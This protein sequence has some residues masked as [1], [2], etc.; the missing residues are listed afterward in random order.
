MA[1]S[2]QKYVFP[3]LDNT[4]GKKISGVS[5]I[6]SDFV[7]C[8]TAYLQKEGVH[9]VQGV[10]LPGMQ[11]AK[12]LISKARKDAGN[13]DLT[14]RGGVDTSG[15][16]IV[17]VT[18]ILPPKKPG[19]SPEKYEHFEI[20]R[21]A[22]KKLVD[23][24]KAQ[25]NVVVNLTRIS[26]SEA[27]AQ[28]D[29]LYQKYKSKSAVMGSAEFKALLKKYSGDDIINR[30]ADKQAAKYSTIVQKAD[31]ADF[32][33]VTT[34][35]VVLAAHGGAVAVSGT[36]IGTSLG[37]KSAADIVKLLTQNS[38]KKKNLSKTFSGTVLLSGCFTAAGSG[39]IPDGYNYST[40][41]GQVYSLLKS[42]GYTKCNVKGMPGPSVTQNSGDKA[43][44]HAMVTDKGAEAL[45]QQMQAIEKEFNGLV[46]SHG[47]DKAKVAGDPKSAAL[48]DKWKKL[49][50][51]RGNVLDSQTDAK[52]AA[53]RI[54]AL[55]G[56]F[57][58][59]GR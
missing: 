38:D 54:E 22:F 40:F 58:L 46:A 21:P 53:N 55:V 51:E 30:A 13:N 31:E 25:A 36:V 33:G 15:N 10:M 37:S 34:G 28:V 12:D 26:E 7:K 39:A 1:V 23:E 8:V 19:G 56:T 9:D 50:A 35:T 47:G 57:G 6:Q 43:A 29:Q 4:A 48:A 45:L 20:V 14:V 44:R 18:G 52:K 24:M 27:L 59:R 5:D 41:A 42:G 11:K 49:K 3:A 2:Y 32:G 16:L 17:S